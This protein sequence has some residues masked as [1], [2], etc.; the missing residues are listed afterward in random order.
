MRVQHRYESW[1]VHSFPLCSHQHWPVKL[2]WWRQPAGR[3]TDLRILD[4]EF[5]ILCP[6]SINDRET[7]SNTPSFSALLKPFTKAGGSVWMAHSG[8]CRYQ[9]ASGEIPCYRPCGLVLLLLLL[10]WHGPWYVQSGPVPTNCCGCW[11]HIK[12]PQRGIPWICTQDK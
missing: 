5:Q 3:H 11:M 12:K 9:S 2:Q 10:P 8:S 1:T 4:L 6:E 7:C